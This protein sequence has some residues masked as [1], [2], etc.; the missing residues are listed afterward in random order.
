MLV[1][2]FSNYLLEKLIIP[3][4]EKGKYRVVDK[5]LRESLQ[6]ENAYICELHYK[7]DHIGLTSKLQ[8]IFVM[9]IALT[10]TSER[11]KSISSSSFHG[12]SISH[13][14]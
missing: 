2:A 11:E 1:Q 7:K 8:K 5:T 4:L 10:K 9:L 14:C 6:L 12:P 3:T 13:K